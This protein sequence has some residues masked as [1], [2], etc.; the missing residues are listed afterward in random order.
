MRLAVMVATLR[1]PTA[2]GGVPLAPSIYLESIISE[3][4][5]KTYNV[6][7]RHANLRVNEQWKGLRCL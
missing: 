2:G 7:I 1:L 3:I 5:E 6:G 4:D